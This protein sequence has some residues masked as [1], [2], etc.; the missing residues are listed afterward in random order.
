[1]EPMNTGFFNVFG[2]DSR[3]QAYTLEAIVAAVL[4]I[5]VVLFVAPSFAAPASNENA[6]DIKE[7]A[8]LESDISR[9]LEQHSSNGHLKA[10]I[11][12]YDNNGN[13]W[14]EDAPDPEEYPY[15]RDDTNATSIPTITDNGTTFTSRYIEA[16]GPVGTS[17][18]ELEEEHDAAISVYLYPESTSTNDS[19]RIEF[20]NPGNNAPDTIATETVTITLYDN[21]HLRSPAPAHNRFSSS[22]P[23]DYGNGERL[24]DAENFPVP[25]MDNPPADSSVYNTVTVQ[26]VAYENTENDE[27]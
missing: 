20:I 5:T 23:Q 2:Q 17:I 26:V 10:L 6:E 12:N 1:M 24:A 27:Q 13:T 3:G 14:Q 22:L 19:N 8:E 15:S 25:E 16:P 18:L 11:L 4:I 21:D 9:M 7:N